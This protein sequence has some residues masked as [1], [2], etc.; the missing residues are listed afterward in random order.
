VKRLL[1]ITL[2]LIAGSTLLAGQMTGRKV[3]R[4][5]KIEREITK[6]EEDWHSCFVRHDAALLDRILADEYIAVGSN[7]KS[8]NKAD[9]LEDV[10]SDSAVYEYSTPYD[11]DIRPYGNTVVV[12]GS[13]KEKGHY[14]SGRQF[15]NE[16]RW[17]DVFVKRR[18]RWQCVAAHVAVVPAPKSD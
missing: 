11:L 3:S 18:G 6:V 1:G 17:T 10:K 5:P 15:V 14:P 7:G 9:A 8:N 16:Y 4:D 13:T 2:S 12:V